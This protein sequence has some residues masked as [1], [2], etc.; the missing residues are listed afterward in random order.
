MSRGITA[1]TER[2]GKAGGW[3]T[4]PLV[5]KAVALVGLVAFLAGI[6]YLLI[7][8]VLMALGSLGIGDSCSPGC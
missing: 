2:S 1:T 7:T 4:L 5:V 3:R 8:F 6:G